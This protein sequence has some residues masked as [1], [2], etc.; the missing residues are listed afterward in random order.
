LSAPVD[1]ALEFAQR[2]PETTRTRRLTWQDPLPPAAAGAG[3][4]GI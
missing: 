1:A 3:M 2:T 4:A